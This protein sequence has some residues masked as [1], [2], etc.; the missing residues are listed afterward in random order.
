MTVA[1]HR[2]RAELANER[3]A[4]LA[5]EA[6]DLQRRLKFEHLERRRDAALRARSTAN[7]ATKPT[8]PLAIGAALA[9]MRIQSHARRRL[10]RCRF[11]VA[12]PPRMQASTTRDPG[13]S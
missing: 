11:A 12:T 8:Q 4:R 13:R 3:G 1:L 5:E 10:V 7:I 6:S 9:A 2:L